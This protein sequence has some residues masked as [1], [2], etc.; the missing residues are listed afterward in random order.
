VSIWTR[1]AVSQSEDW[2][3]RLTEEEAE[4]EVEED[5]SLDMKFDA[6]KQ[7]SHDLPPR[8]DLRVREKAKEKKK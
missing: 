6:E 1:S 5:S 3:R 2:L 4:E 7:E 8:E